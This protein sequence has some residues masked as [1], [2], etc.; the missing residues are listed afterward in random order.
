MRGVF[1]L[2]FLAVVAC[3]EEPSIHRERIRNT[4]STEQIGYVDLPIARRVELPPLPE[5]QDEC[6][7]NGHIGCGSRVPTTRGPYRPCVRLA[8]GHFHF[9]QCNTPLAVVFDDA[10][11]RFTQVARD[12]AVGEA[13]RTE[14]IGAE[15]PWLA[16]DR[17]GSGCIESERELFAGFEALAML[18]ANDDGVVDARDPA[19]A[20]LVLWSDRNQDKRCTPDELTALHRTSI[21]LAHLDGVPKLGSFE[22]DTA[23]FE[24]GGRIVDVWLQASD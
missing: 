16:L 19:F 24:G 12:F 20:E 13:R 18:D 8:D 23:F 14:W 7:P 10:P 9:R 11:V 15:T 17:D 22:G 4:V 6:T 2:S 5:V 3:G 1:L 21:P